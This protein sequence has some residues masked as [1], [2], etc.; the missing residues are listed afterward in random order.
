M[1]FPIFLGLLGGVLFSL[2]AITFLEISPESDMSVCM[3]GGGV[4]ASFLLLCALLF[5]HKGKRSRCVRLNA[6]SA[7]YGALTLFTLL[8]TCI[9]ADYRILLLAAACSVLLVGVRFLYC[10]FV[11]TN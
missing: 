11:R 4:F 7:V 9:R 5:F 2:C 3:Y 8:C 1:L 10:K 6:T